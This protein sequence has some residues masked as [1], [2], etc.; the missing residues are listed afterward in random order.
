MGDDV[1]DAFLPLKLTLDFEQARFHQRATVLVPYPLPYDDVHLP[2]LVLES[3]ECHT[4]R[5]ARALAHQNNA[6]GAYRF[7][8][9]NASDLMCGEKLFGSQRVTQ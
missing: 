3:K 9:R 7:T 5:G 6:G 2:R 4:A 8:V 1:H